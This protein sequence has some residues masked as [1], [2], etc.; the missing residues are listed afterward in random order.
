MLQLFAYFIHNE[1]LVLNNEE[2]GDIYSLEITKVL[3]APPTLAPPKL[4]VV[5]ILPFYSFALFEGLSK[6]ATCLRK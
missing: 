3:P 6:K 1:I 2:A 5:K 4:L